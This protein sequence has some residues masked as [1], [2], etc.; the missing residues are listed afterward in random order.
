MDDNKFKNR[1][2]LLVDD[3]K[4]IHEDFHEILRSGKVSTKKLDELETEFF[5]DSED[6]ASPSPVYQLESAFQGQDALA[7]VKT[8]NEKKHYPYV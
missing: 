6:T 3:Y 7:L 8:A 2:I 1:A 4:P 5:G